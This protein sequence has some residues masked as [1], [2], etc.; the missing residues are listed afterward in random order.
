MSFFD[1]SAITPIDQAQ[2]PESVRNGDQAAKNAY[3]AGLAFEQI[4]VNELTT[5]LAATAS[6]SDG[7]DGSDGTDSASG[8]MGSS[9][10]ASSMYSQLLPTALTSA[11]MGSGGTGM[12][13]QLAS[14]IDPGLGANV[15]SAQT[16]VS[17]GAAVSASAPTSSVATTTTG[18][19]APSAAAGEGSEGLQ[20]SESTEDGA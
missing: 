6:S 17:G 15:A 4:L 7:S 3:Q 2:V 5:E 12:A 18:G 19:V 9:D 1:T 20:E 14:A 13:L 8:L 11:V 16:P 10:P